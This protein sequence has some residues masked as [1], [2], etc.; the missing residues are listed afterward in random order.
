MRRLAE[1]EDYVLENEDLTQLAVA[2]AFS[3][4]VAT[5]HFPPHLVRPGLQQAPS[6]G[7]TFVT[8]RPRRIRTYRKYMPHPA[9]RG[10]GARCGPLPTFGGRRLAPA[11]RRGVSCPFRA[12]STSTSRLPGTTLPRMVRID[13]GGRG[14]DAA[15]SPPHVHPLTPTAAGLLLRVAGARHA[16][17]AEFLRSRHRIAAGQRFFSSNRLAAP[18]APA[19]R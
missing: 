17:P 8:R 9:D 13:R 10:H 15:T 6:L 11:A 16:V 4:A 18:G 12:R 2:E 3:Q 5:R 14:A 1:N 7:G 19:L